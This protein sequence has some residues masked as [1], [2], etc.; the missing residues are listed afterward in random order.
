M[1]LFT[2][3]SISTIEELV[4]YESAILDAAKTAR[5]DLTAKLKLAQGELG[6]ELEALLRR[7]QE[8][9]DPV[10]VTL[11]P[12]GLGNVVVTEALHKWH[13]FRTLSLAYREAYN[14]QLNDRFQG[15]WQEYD[16][17][18]GWARQ[19]LLDGGIGMTSAPVP[20]PCQPVLASVAGQ[21]GA[22]TYF[23]RVTWVAEGGPEGAP[24]AI[25][26]LT[27][28]GASALTVAA[29]NPPAV[30]AGWNVYASYSPEGLTRQNDAPLALGATWTEPTAGLTKGKPA[31][32]GQRPDTFL[33]VTGVLNRG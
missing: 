1:A 21:A 5:I 8:S 20:R 24:S 16:K 30:A 26:A 3:G 13:T 17:L 7:R 27:T 19:T 15:K 28:A 29:A 33:R 23:V 10:L 6:V 18:A 32:C 2:D 11:A 14:Q 22:A 9:D 25:T 4:E 12:Q 31:G